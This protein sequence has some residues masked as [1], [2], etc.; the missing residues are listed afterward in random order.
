VTTR[1]FL[2]AVGTPIAGLAVLAAHDNPALYLYY[3][4]LALVLVAAGGYGAAWL[5]RS[6]RDEARDELARRDRA[7]AAAAEARLTD[8][9]TATAVRVPRLHAVPTQRTGAHDDLPVA[10]E[11]WLEEITKPGGWS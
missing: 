11:S 4:A 6:E 5:F 3:L 7:D 1:A 9:A 2:A 10:D 8:P